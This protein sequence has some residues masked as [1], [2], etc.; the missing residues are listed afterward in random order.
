MFPVYI[1]SNIIGVLWSKM[2][3]TCTLTSLGAITGLRF[4]KMIRRRKIRI[5]ILGIGRE[6]L[7][8]AR[9]KGV[10]LEPLGEKLNVEF[11]LDE[12]GS[13][14]WCKHMIIRFIGFIH[15]KTESAML[16]DIR[17]CR[18]TEIEYLN[19]LIKSYGEEKVID[20]PLNTK[21]VKLVEKLESGSLKP[22]LDNIRYFKRVQ[23]HN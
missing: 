23:F 7:A 21:V 4:G 16:A 6:V 20:T 17:A 5:L 18:K 13:P 1:S 12:K 19:A 14:L 11:L 3:I 10:N 2:C 22:S 9:A 15:R 8:V